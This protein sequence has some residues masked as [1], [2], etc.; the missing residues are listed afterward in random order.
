MSKSSENETP[1]KM[2]RKISKEWEKDFRTQIQSGNVIDIQTNVPF[3][4]VCSVYIQ[5]KTHQ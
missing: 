2:P 1:R 4:E 5:L 3:T